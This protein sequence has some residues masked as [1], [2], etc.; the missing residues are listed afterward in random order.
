MKKPS[1]AVLA[2][3]IATLL[4]LAP[5]QLRAEDAAP[6]TAAPPAT[7]PDTYRV[8]ARIVSA[9]RYEQ[10]DSLFLPFGGKALALYI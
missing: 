9:E 10:R 3:V 4:F 1:Q 8:P 5:L 6:G 7:A 2:G